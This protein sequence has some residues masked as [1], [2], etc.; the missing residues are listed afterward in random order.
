MLHSSLATSQ[1]GYGGAGARVFEPVAQRGLIDQ[2]AD[3]QPLGDEIKDAYQGS[4]EVA[5][6]QYKEDMSELLILLGRVA[7]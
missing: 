7:Q 1:G 4:D 5:D 3:G 2:T 6:R